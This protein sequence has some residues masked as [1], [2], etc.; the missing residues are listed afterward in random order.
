MSTFEKQRRRMVDRQLASRGITNRAVLSAMG[1]VPR[2]RFVPEKLHD[3]AYEDGPLPI[4]SG[5]TIS[6]PFI[7]AA[8]V[9]ALD[10]EPADRV[11]EI[12]AGSGYA[13]AVMSR[14]V[15]RVVAIERHEEL[16]ASAGER[17]GNLGYDNVR[18]VHG[19]GTRGCPEEAPF[20]AIV[21]AAAGPRIPESLRRQLAVGG[22]MVIPVGPSRWEQRLVRVTRTAEDSF[23]EEEME[24]VR[25]VPLVGEE[26][27]QEE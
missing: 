24:P 22:R 10:L 1:E 13:A 25:F 9:E 26:G 5:Q 2:E 12:G 23:D 11:L 16:A 19:D 4:G 3:Y 14:I 6:Q 18:I 15:D 21:V 7:V 8:M 17:L 27:W 20:D